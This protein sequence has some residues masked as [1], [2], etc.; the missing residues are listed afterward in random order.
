MFHLA[1][2]HPAPCHPAPCHPAP[3]H[4]ADRVLGLRPPAASASTKAVEA[5][6]LLAGFALSSERLLQAL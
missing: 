1:P 2:C 3:R 6:V 5:A 4:P